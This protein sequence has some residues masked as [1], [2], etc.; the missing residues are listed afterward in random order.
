MR[1]FVFFHAAFIEEQLPDILLKQQEDL[2]MTHIATQMKKDQKERLIQF[3][4]ALVNQEKAEVIVPPKKNEEG[5]WFGGGNLTEDSAGRIYLV[6]RFR[7]KGDSRTGIDAGERGSELLIFESGNRGKNFKPLCRFTKKDLALPGQPVLSIEGTSLRFF[8]EGVELFLSTEK[9]I[10]YPEDLKEFQKP[11]TGVWTVDYMRAPGVAALKDAEL[12]SLFSSD[13]PEFLHVKDPVSFDLPSG[14]TGLIF[15]TH[16]YNWSCSNS[17]LSLRKSGSRNFSEPDY[18]FFPRGNTWDVA[19][20]RI[21]GVLTVPR[22]G[23][24]S[25][26]PP[27]SLV[28]YDGGECVRNLDQHK[29][30]VKRPRGYSCEELGGL[31]VIE[32][33]DFSTIRRLSTVLPLFVSPR[34]TGCS[35]YV[36]TLTIE[37]G[38]HAVWQQSQQDS[39]QPLVHNFLPMEEVEKILG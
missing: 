10:S 6:G 15:C 4:Q 2:I 18:R 21:T 27:Y 34:G 28:F 32:N 38:I 22:A 23:L 35:R 3:A 31:A 14:D 25:E 17:A 8:E 7:N 39:S 30:A 20:S 24:F 29:E 1:Y 19:M 33:D 9:D 36:E 37:E 13:D 26:G 12:S 11:G 16:P 5:F